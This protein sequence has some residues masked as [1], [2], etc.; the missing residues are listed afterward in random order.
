MTA[1]VMLAAGGLRVAYGGGVVLDQV[2]LRVRAGEWVTIL[3]PNGS[4]KTTLLRAI[5]AYL[6]PLA[7]SVHVDGR[8]A[9]SYRR[10]ELARIMA[11]VG[12][13]VP[14]DFPLAVSEFVM[15]GR[16]PHAP[17]WGSPG[18]RDHQAVARALE[19]TGTATLAD[20]SLDQLSAGERQ[21]A[22]VARALAQEPAV[23]LLDEPTVHLDICRQVEML[24]LLARLRAATG[25]T[26]LAV[27]H[28]INLAALYSDRLVLM[29]D[30]RP[31]A[32][33][34]PARVLTAETLEAVFGCRVAVQPHPLRPV[35]QVLVIP[36]EAAGPAGE[37]AET[38]R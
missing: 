32:A 25:L 37:T 3:G 18:S 16:I 8:P 31:V 10:E 33:G 28:D 2:D 23:L 9:A 24:D 4:G 14:G 27:L 7:G 5:G 22:L 38:A 20:R 19:Q 35:P 36:G 15:L 21:R 30:G 1:R 34:P 26:I 12:V 11:A 13:N 6:E 29:R 17:G